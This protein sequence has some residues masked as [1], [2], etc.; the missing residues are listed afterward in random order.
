[1]KKEKRETYPLVNT[2][3]C[4][5]TYKD[6]LEWC[7]KMEQK[8]AAENS[9][10]Y[11]RW[12]S[13]E[14]QVNYYCDM[15]DLMYS[16]LKDRFFLITG[17]LGLW[18]GR[19]EIKPVLIKGIVPALKKCFGSCDDMDAELNIKEGVINVQSHHHDGTNCFSLLLLN[20][21]GL[22][23]AEAMNDKGE[24]IEYNNRWWTKIKSINDIWG[25]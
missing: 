15:D 18:W 3:A 24:K 11:W 19:P 16:K 6:Y 7:E 9:N 25:D 12:C 21:N 4:Q 2:S 1:M 10:E 13:D 8:P 17:K 22:K 20:K 5:F 23:W 14:A